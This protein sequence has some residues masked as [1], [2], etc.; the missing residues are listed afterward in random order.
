MRGLYG[1]AGIVSIGAYG[2]A[3]VFAGTMFAIY[4][5]VHS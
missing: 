3:L 2:A 5:R 1:I 4:V